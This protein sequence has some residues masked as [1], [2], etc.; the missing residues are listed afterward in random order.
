MKHIYP[1]CRRKR[2]KYMK[3]GE[4]RRR[5]RDYLRGGKKGEGNM[6]NPSCAGQK[7]RECFSM[8][9]CIRERGKKKM[10]VSATMVKT[11][12]SPLKGAGSLCRR[13]GTTGRKRG[14]GLIRE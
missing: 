1:R 6:S 9:C 11:D 8:V 4:S 2:L 7:K 12:S 14:G 5:K 10:G 3:S 13:G